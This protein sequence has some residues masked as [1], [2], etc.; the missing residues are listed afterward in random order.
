MASIERGQTSNCAAPILDIFFRKS[1]LLTDV[2]ALEFQIFERVTSPPNL[3]QTFPVSGRATVDLTDCPTGDKISTGRYVAE[4]TVP[5][6][7]PVGDHVI[8]WFFRETLTS[9]E[10]QF[11]QEFA[12]FAVGA[13]PGA[14]GYCTVAELRAAGVPSTGINGKTDAELLVLIARATTLVDFYTGRFFEPRSAVVR[15][16]GTGRSGLLVGDPIISITSIKLISEDFTPATQDIDLADVRIYNRHLTQRLTN[17]DDRENPRI[18]FLEFDTRHEH[19]GFPG[20][21]AAHHL[22]HPH[23]W[24]EGTQNVELDGVFGYTDFD[25]GDPQGKTPDLISQAT[26]LI[27][28]RLLTPAFSEPDKRSDILNAWRVTEY[29][30]RDQT[31]KYANPKDLGSRGVGAFTGDPEIDSILA[32]YTRPPMFGAV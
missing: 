6:T 16:D 9:Q 25:S 22:F 29:K 7:E 10:Q 21:D 14:G 2:P 3:V 12:V 17:P 13:A 27:V 19:I 4:W 28:L 15:L 31:I 30:T 18:E 32:A 11:E 24:P 20:G 26:C 8:R 5:V 23:R 1:G